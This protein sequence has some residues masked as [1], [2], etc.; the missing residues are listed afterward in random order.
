MKL[1]IVKTTFYEIGWDDFEK[2]M[3]ECWDNRNKWRHVRIPFLELLKRKI[4]I[5]AHLIFRKKISNCQ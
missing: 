2:K 3:R 5:K 1:Y 4:V